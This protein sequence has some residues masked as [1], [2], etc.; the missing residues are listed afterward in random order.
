MAQ[1]EVRQILAE[2]HGREHVD[3]GV[4]GYKLDECDN[5]DYI[6]TPWSF[7]EISQF[8]SGLDGEQ[9]H[10]LLGRYYQEAID[11]LFHERDTRT[12]GQVRSS[13]A[14]AAP[15]PFVLYS[16]LYNHKEYIRGVVNCGFGGLL[17]T[18]EVRH[19]RSDEDLIRRLQSVVLS[20]QVSING[21]YIKHPP[22]KQW[23][24]QANNNDELHPERERVERVCRK[25][26][27]LRMQLV[28]YL[29]SALF[30][31]WREGVPPFRALV[32]DW[33][34][35]PLVREID[36]QYLIGDRL[37]AAPVV[38]GQPVRGVYL[39]EGTWHDFWTGARHE[40]GRSIEVEVPLE[41]SP[42]Y[43]RDGAVLPTAEPTLHSGDAAA[44][45]LTVRVY[46]DG[47]R[48]A[49]LVED[50]TTSYAFSRGEYVL[51]SL[52]WDAEAQRGSV[53]RRGSFSGPRYRVREWRVVGE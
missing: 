26:L 11:G 53:E 40:G 27:E 18:P 41:Q 12:F 1:P 52:T 29:Y 38:A 8:P 46:G 45:E 23:Q 10:V 49:V 33:P 6:H 22:W 44:W 15:Y 30:S 37:M 13:G 47:A 51:V 7:P 14:L 42:L 17:W 20:P 4:S 31:Y 5:S 32:L 28:P 9:M 19:A 21:W 36:D 50:D 34:D 35:D 48:G 24:R 16:D 39:P 2:Q 25:W 3:R 43:V